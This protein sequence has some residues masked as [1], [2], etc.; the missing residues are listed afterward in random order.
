[1]SIQI[2]CLKIHMSNTHNPEYFSLCS[3]NWPKS[4]LRNFITEL[5]CSTISETFKKI[6][7]LLHSVGSGYEKWLRAGHWL[8]GH[9]I[10]LVCPSST[11]SSSVLDF[12]GLY[13][14]SSILI[15]WP[16]MLPLG[17]PCSLIIS[18]ALCRLGLCA[19]DIGDYWDHLPTWFRW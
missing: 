7:Y 16:S 11:F 5:T 12:I 6:L 14:L 3:P 1:M 17:I 13:K 2:M 19:T 8:R 15:G 10:L 9:I 4:S 18:I